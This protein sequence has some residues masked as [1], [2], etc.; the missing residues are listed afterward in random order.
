MADDEVTRLYRMYGPV[1]YAR[2]RSLLRDDGE[3]EDATQETFVRVHR[4]LDRLPPSRAVLYWIHRV[5]TNYCLNQLR[6]RRQV[7]RALP[8]EAADRP[9]AAASEGGGG[10]EERLGDRDLAARLVER[11]HPK[12]KPVAWLYHVDGFEQEEVARLL[13]ISRRTVAARLATFLENARKFVRRS[14]S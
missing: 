12:V 13:G 4:H 1:I 3:A 10:P 5:A 2:C 6:N 14:G 7:A 8:I 9:V 11:A